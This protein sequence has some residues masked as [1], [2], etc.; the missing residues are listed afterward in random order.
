MS[1]SRISALVVLTI[2][3]TFHSSAQNQVT[4]GSERDNTLFEDT[5]GSLSNGAGPNMFAGRNNLGQTR[6]AVISF[7]VAAVIPSGATID[8]VRLTL[9]MSQSSSG[10][11]NI[12]LYT[13]TSDWGEGTSNSTGG[14]GAPATTDDATWVHTFF[15]AQF[16]SAVGGDYSA[17]VSD[18]R[19]V[20]SIGFYTWGSTSQMVSDVQSWVDDP[21]GNHGW[22]LKGNEGANQTAK[23]FDTKENS[24]PANRP[25]LTLY[26]TGPLSVG[27]EEGPRPARF[28]LGQSYPNPFNPSATITYTVADREFVEIRIFDIRGREVALLVEGTMDPGT[29]ETTW[30]A[31]NHAGGVY[32]YRMQ[33]GGFAATRRMVLVK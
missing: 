30:D 4:I 11:E 7:D 2:S 16:W 10:P 31:S 26:W 12:E 5:T 15:D 25:A 19:E 24:M 3:W 29:Y 28:D 22:I 33:A 27:D 18:V 17:V 1:F 32:Y 9:F 14:Q 8:S 13:V 23:R 20:D 21:A 6:R